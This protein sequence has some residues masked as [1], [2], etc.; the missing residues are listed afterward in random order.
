M[1]SKK[2]KV[3]VVGLGVYGSAVASQLALMGA[4]VIGIDQFEP[5]HSHGSSHGGT[6]ITRIANFEGGRYVETALRTIEIYKWMQ[7]QGFSDRPLF[8]S[9]GVLLYGPRGDIL[10][11]THGVTNPIKGTID[12]ARKF[13]VAHEVLSGADIQARFPGFNLSDA[14]ALDTM[15]YFEK[16][17]GTLFPERCVEAQLKLARQ[18]GAQ[19]LMNTRVAD[20]SDTGSQ[21]VV[22]LANGT[23]IEADEVV[24]CAGPW[25]RDFVP[26]ELRQHFK[27][28]RHVFGWFQSQDPAAFHIDN[29]PNFARFFRMPDG[30]V[31]F[32]YGFPNGHEVVKVA[33]EQGKPVDVNDP[34]RL[35]VDDT[36]VQA[37]FNTVAPHIKGLTGKIVTRASCVYTV[38]PDHQFLIGEH[39]DMQGVHIVSAC[40]GHG[41]KHAAAL[42]ERLAQEIMGQ[43]T[44]G[45]L[46]ADYG[47][48]ARGIGAP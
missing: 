9:N 8:Q 35:T 28:E 16:D 19:L 4:D 45:S 11:A 17:S 5:P 25:V 36:E 26:E 31:D 1:N 27:V 32:F 2:K 21:K 14:E 41:F 38:T 42:G 22:M 40:S 20:V 6:R 13:N 7:Q 46:N 39:P 37:L 29:H 10:E 43:R 12:V 24:V 15:G 30:S 44:R 47:W 23:T 18:C 34:M 48:K 33:K 3:V